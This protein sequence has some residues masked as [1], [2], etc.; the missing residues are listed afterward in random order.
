MLIKI[1]KKIIKKIFEYFGY[2]VIFNNIPVDFS[3]FEKDL[4]QKVKNY[5]MTSPERIK[6]LIDAVYYINRNNISGSFVECGVWRGGSM[7]AA[8]LTLKSLKKIDRKFY[9]FDTYE[10]MSEPTNLDVDYLDKDAKGLLNQSLKNK[11]NNIWCYSPI[12]DVKKNIYST[13]YPAENVNFIKG[14]VENTIPKYCPER[15]ALLRLDTDWYESTK[16]ELEQLFPRLVKGGIL[17]ID[18]YFFWKG[19][20]KAVDE[21]FKDKKN[22]FFHRIDNSGM[23]II[24]NS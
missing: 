23:L 6:S 4:I 8:M 10:G 1:I 24:K 21:Y 12:E 9:L 20:K 15:I 2:Q 16:H 3:K 22:Y 14:K 7:M 5:T 11:E 19:S 18:D 17:I 13:N